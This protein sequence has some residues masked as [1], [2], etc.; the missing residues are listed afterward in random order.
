MGQVPAPRSQGAAGAGC[1][2]ER[3]SRASGSLGRGGG[4]SL[5]EAPWGASLRGMEDLQKACWGPQ[6]RGGSSE[7]QR[8][9]PGSGKCQNLEGTAGPGRRKGGLSRDGTQLQGSCVLGRGGRSGRG[10]PNSA[11]VG[12]NLQETEEGPRPEQAFWRGPGVAKAQSE[13]P[14]PRQTGLGAP[15]A[16]GSPSPPAPR[17][18]SPSKKRCSASVSSTTSMSGLPGAHSAPAPLQP[19]PGA[20]H[21]RRGQRDRPGSAPAAVPPGPPPRS[22][23]ARPWPG[24]CPP[25]TRPARRPR[26]AP[27][28]GPPQPRAG[29]DARGSFWRRS[30]RGALLIELGGRCA[31]RPLCC[32]RPGPPQ[33]SPASGVREDSRLLNLRCSEPNFRDSPRFI[34]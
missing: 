11:E 18:P 26:A 14:V 6:P 5:W 1:Q 16:R 25:R 4:P 23:P 20:R 13:V 9:S 22:P 10:N 32:G 15:S 27:P 30:A 28:A 31:P 19:G 33:S 3:H 21:R 2:S 29:Q 7:A 24:P 17:G 12:I 8:R 34:C